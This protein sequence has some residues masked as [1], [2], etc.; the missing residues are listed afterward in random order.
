MTSNS[1]QKAHQICPPV[2]LVYLAIILSLL[3]LILGPHYK[4][5]WFADHLVYTQMGCTQTFEHFSYWEGGNFAER[6]T[7]L[8]ANRI[9][10]PFF[11]TPAVA[12]TFSVTS[13]HVLLI[14]I[15]IIWLYGKAGPASATLVGC[16]LV[17]TMFQLRAHATEVLA[18]PYAMFFVLL[19]MIVAAEHSLITTWPRTGGAI[20]GLLLWCAIFAKIHYGIFLITISSQFLLTRRRKVFGGIV[21]G[22]VLGLVIYI[23]L[24]MSFYPVS[25]WRIYPPF[26]LS[27][28]KNYFTRGVGAG[29]G[30]NGAGSGLEWVE[31]FLSW[32]H[33]PVAM[34]LFLMFKR[35][36]EREASRQPS[37]KRTGKSMKSHYRKHGDG[38]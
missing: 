31:W 13:L 4:P 16:F 33:F 25:F 15:P 32:R 19:A 12:S 9:F 3:F 29:L 18:D 11:S 6:L 17:F 22:L 14:C 20:I 24:F 7:I 2:F 21:L 35:I 8:F 30:P 38:P 26:V 28:F 36:Y 23:I 34:I 37:F 1:K 27:V 10:V 5:P